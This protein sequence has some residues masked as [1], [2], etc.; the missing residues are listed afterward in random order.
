MKV[1]HIFWVTSFMLERLEEAVLPHID[2]EG[3]SRQSGMKL[4]HKYSEQTASSF[5]LK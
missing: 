3:S 2:L 4:L 5:H 1:E